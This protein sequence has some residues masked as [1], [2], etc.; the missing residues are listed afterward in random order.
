M[1]WIVNHII[2]TIDW[3][4]GISDMN[5]K[6]LQKA[7]TM[8][9]FIDFKNTTAFEASQI[10]SNVEFLKNEK[11]IKANATVASTLWK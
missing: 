4:I 2:R 3:Q 10:L 1:E 6:T 9:T 11:R 5:Q 7:E 8:N